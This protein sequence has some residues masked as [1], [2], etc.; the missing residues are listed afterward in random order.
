M[1]GVFLWMDRHTL[2]GANLKHRRQD[3]CQIHVV[4]APLQCKCE[5]WTVHYLGS[6]SADKMGHNG[7]PASTNELVDFMPW[8]TGLSDSIEQ[9][10]QRR[11]S[12]VAVG[13]AQDWKPLVHWQVF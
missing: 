13:E 3:L 5:R 1:A 8:Q 9:V 10:D 6:F 2:D 11:F 4:A 12:A 7:C